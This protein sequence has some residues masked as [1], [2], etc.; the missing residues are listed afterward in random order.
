MQEE[1]KKA[2]RNAK[3]GSVYYDPRRDLVLI[4]F[5]DSKGN[6]KTASYDA[7][8]FKDDFNPGWMGIWGK[9]CDRFPHVQFLD[10][11]VVIHHDGWTETYTPNGDGS[12]SID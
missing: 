3:T 11:E 8:K 1:L 12:W 7:E 9:I 5:Y 6:K 2:I 4:T 10:I